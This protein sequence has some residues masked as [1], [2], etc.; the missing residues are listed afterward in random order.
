VRVAENQRFGVDL[1]GYLL[2]LAAPSLLAAILIWIGLWERKL[3]MTVR[4]AAAH[5][6]ER[7]D[8]LVR[9]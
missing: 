9:S 4:D 7:T 3:W 8:P 5:P 2:A 1:P 6:P